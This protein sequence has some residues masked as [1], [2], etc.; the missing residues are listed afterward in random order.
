MKNDPYDRKIPKNPSWSINPE[1][2]AEESDLI[3]YESLYIHAYDSIPGYQGYRFFSN[4]RYIVKYVKNDKIDPS[5]IF[6]T[7][8]DA[9]VGYYKIENKKIFLEFFLPRNY[10]NYHKSEGYID[11]GGNIVVNVVNSSRLFSDGEVRPKIYFKIKA[12]DLKEITPDW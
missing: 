3:S 2:V 5:L 8:T 11:S 7:L 10:G 1:S 12:D 6:S 9:V 4:G